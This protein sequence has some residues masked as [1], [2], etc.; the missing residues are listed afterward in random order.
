MDRQKFAEL[1]RLRRYSE[2]NYR[3]LRNAVHSASQ[4]VIPFLG[5]YLTDLTYV[6]DGAVNRVGHLINFQK[7]AKIA[8]YILEIQQY[9][10][11]T[12]FVHLQ[13]SNLFNTRILFGF[14][15]IF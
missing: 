8:E 7:L 1:E 3:D 4:P 12:S 13:Q 5:V 14:C 11:V 10:Q 15:H 2:Q 6:E 9:Q